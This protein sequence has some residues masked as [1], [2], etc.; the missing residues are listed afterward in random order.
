MLKLTTGSISIFFTL[1][2]AGGQFES[3]QGVN[4]QEANKDVPALENSV[5]LML[6]LNFLFKDNL[7][8]VKQIRQ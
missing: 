7:N 8:F 4:I 2:T 1:T 6:R 5:L 3:L